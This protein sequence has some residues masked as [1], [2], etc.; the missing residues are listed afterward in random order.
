MSPGHG[1][2]DGATVVF[3][4]QQPGLLFE[5][6]VLSG[7]H[8]GAALPLFGECWSIGAHQDADLELYDPGV[9]TRHARLHCV[10][11]RWTVQ[12]QEGLLQDETG[13]AR[14]QIADLAAGKAFAIGGIRLCIANTQSAWVDELAEVTRVQ[15]ETAAARSGMVPA[16]RPGKWLALALS[17][18]VLILAAQVCQPSNTAQALSPK[19]LAVSDRRQLAT[20]HQVHQQLLKMLIERDLDNAIRLQVVD[21]QIILGGDVGKDS[22]ALVSRMLDRFEAQFET[23][24]AII[25]QVQEI[26]TALPFRIVQIIGGQKAHVVLA[27]GR[28]LFFGDEAQGVRLT[29]IDNRRVLFEGAQRYEVSW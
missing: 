26:S 21:E 9:E 27:D 23:P 3:D 25:N 20:T 2:P 16:R 24:V 18:S 1:L 11:G 8:E 15:S 10:D 7:L 13:T 14:A 29:A 22:L 5:L 12:A 19:P 6:R 17:V 28:R 4:S